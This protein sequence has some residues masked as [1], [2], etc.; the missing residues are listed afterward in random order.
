MFRVGFLVSVNSDVIWA[1][2]NNKKQLI[3]G[4]S[5]IPRSIDAVP[6]EVLQNWPAPRSGELNGQFL[7]CPLVDS[8]PPLLWPLLMSAEFP[9]IS[10]FSR[11][12]QVIS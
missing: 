2:P 11:C 12:P 1:P 7:R 6:R 9:R 8:V 5:K 3:K 4:I 10:Y